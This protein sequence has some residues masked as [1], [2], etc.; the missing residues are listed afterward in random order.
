VLRWSPGE[1]FADSLAAW[2]RPMVLQQTAAV[3]WAA[4]GATQQ[5][6]DG[7]GGEEEAGRR[8]LGPAALL[9]LLRRQNVSSVKGVKLGSDPH[10]A[11]YYYHPAPMN[12]SSTPAV[13]Q[14]YK[15]RCFRKADV[16]I[17]DFE[18][19]LRRG[20]RHPAAQRALLRG[21]EGRAGQAGGGGG[22]SSFS[23]ATKLDEWGTEAFHMVQPLAPLQV[24]VSHFHT[25]VGTCFYPK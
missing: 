20:A 10:H 17:D 3:L 1:A 4:T 25:F 16:P 18:L 7:K 5:G 14:R 22:F 6:Y 12:A 8:G 23:Y 9:R 24:T 21:E 19:L 13:A 2:D 11:F 15:Q